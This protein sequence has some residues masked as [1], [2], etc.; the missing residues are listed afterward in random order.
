M[1]VRTR[2]IR[3]KTARSTKST[4]INIIGSIMNRKNT[5]QNSSKTR[6]REWVR[7]KYYN[8]E[9]KVV[10]EIAPRSFADMCKG[11]TPSEQKKY[12]SAIHKYKNFTVKVLKDYLSRNGQPNVGDKEYLIRKCADGAAFGA[13]PECP[14]CSNSVLYYSMWTG[15]YYCI[16]DKKECKAKFTKKEIKRNRWYAPKAE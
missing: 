14:V 12:F 6:Y 3:N 9:I 10:Q 8:P 1:P 7:Q 15:F 2:S 13:I 11:Y 4:K 16:A 5:S